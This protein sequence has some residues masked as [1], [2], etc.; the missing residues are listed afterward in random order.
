MCCAYTQTHAHTLFA[1][2]LA[3]STSLLCVSFHTMLMAIVEKKFQAVRF[4][5]PLYLIWLNLFLMFVLL[6]CGIGLIQIY[7]HIEKCPRW[8]WIP[9]AGQKD[10]H[11]YQWDH[12][13]PG[14]VHR[15]KHNPIVESAQLVSF[16]IGMLIK[17]SNSLL[18]KFFIDP[19]L[20]IG[21]KISRNKKK[22]LWKSFCIKHHLSIIKN[23]K[24]LNIVR[25]YLVGIIVRENN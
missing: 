7:D 15:K 4:F 16:C 20:L 8:I 22:L 17:W 5:L 3:T 21:N 14:I 10:R 25:W 9:N 23:M 13:C 24:S 18:T 6:S 12:E 11:F 2:R 19:K 1:Q